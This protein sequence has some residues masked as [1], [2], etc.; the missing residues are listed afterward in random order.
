MP[1]DTFM[2]ISAVP[3]ESKDQTHTKEI[4][5][6]AWTWGMINNGSAHLGGGQVLVRLACRTCLLQSM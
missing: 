2:K 4:D 1:V 6:L 5:V 3:G